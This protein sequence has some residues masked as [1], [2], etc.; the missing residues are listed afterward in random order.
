MTDTVPLFPFGHGPSYTSFQLSDMQLLKANGLLTVSCT[1][2]NVGQRSGAEVVQLYVAP[3]PSSVN[4]PVKELKEFQ[5]VWLAAGAEKTVTISLDL[6]RATSY[7]DEKRNCWCSHHGV[8][9]ILVGT[10][11]RGKLLESSVQK[12]ETTFWLNNSQQSIREID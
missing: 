8:Y 2:R 10:C 12:D 11:S 7:W 6:V 9:G 4:R 1:L 5:K 3:P